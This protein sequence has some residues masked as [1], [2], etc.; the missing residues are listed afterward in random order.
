MSE[1]NLFPAELRVLLLAGAGGV[2]VT[3]GWIAAFCKKERGLLCGLVQGLFYAALLVVLS[4]PSG[5]LTEEPPLLRFA[6]LI[7]CGSIGGLLG[8]VTREKKRR[9]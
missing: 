4:V 6:V 9:S 8:M 7:L 2:M 3:A 5:T 1:K